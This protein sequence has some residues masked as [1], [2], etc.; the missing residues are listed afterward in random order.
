MNRKR[1]ASNEAVL[2]KL[3][4]LGFPE[5]FCLGVVYVLDTDFLSDR[6]LRFLQN[7]HPTS[8]EVVADEVV[9]IVEERNKYM[10]KYKNTRSYSH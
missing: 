9:A 10:Q 8:Q 3:R 7:A 2:Q 6:M 4:E 1:P 5:V